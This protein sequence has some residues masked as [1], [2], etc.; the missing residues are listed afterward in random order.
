MRGAM[1]YIGLTMP[2][3]IC[4]EALLESSYRGAVDGCGV[5]GLLLGRKHGDSAS[6]DDFQQGK[7]L[8]S[9]VLPHGHE[10]AVMERRFQD[11]HGTWCGVDVALLL[12]QPVLVKERKVAGRGEFW[13]SRCGWCLA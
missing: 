6:E 3:P 13:W 1:S 4:E 5:L 11:H 12:N 2:G 9:I 7:R 8:L 10:R